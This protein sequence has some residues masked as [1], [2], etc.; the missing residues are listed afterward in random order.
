MTKVVFLYCEL[1][2]YT[3]AGLKSLLERYPE[4]D[5]TVV[6]WGEN[7]LTPFSFQALDGMNYRSL[8][9]FDSVQAL[10]SYC[11]RIN[12]D[13]VFVNSWRAFG[14]EYMSASKY[15]LQKGVPTICM[16]DNQWLGTMKQWLAVW[17]SPF[18]LK[19]HF[20]L[21]WGSGD[22]QVD[23]ALRAGYT[24]A[25]I[26][27]GFY[28]CDVELY[29]SLN[30][31][32]RRNVKN[33]LFVGRFVKVKG[34]GI[35]LRAFEEVVKDFPD[36]TLTLVGIGDIDQFMQ[37]TNP[38]VIVEQ[39][40]QPKDLVGFFEKAT[41]FCLPSVFEPWG[42]VIHEA[43]A[44]GLP[45]VCSDACGAGDAFVRD[46]V[47]GYVFRKGNQI[48]LTDALRGL[49]NKSNEELRSMGEV[50]RELASTNTPAIWAETFVNIVDVALTAH[51]K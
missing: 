37:K 13:V 7:K 39:F 2:G 24:K 42:V 15:F 38:N 22:R 14:S 33:I 49:M 50:S 20:G 27:K 1:M 40:R 30:F 36:W 25:E 46:G 41:F 19:R 43:A 51:S 44:A 6:S 9:E 29:G 8:S 3:L 45:I 21:M 26:F 32:T 11:E 28:T 31:E 35:L 5:L 18:F 16:F 48:A 23:F 34:I 10:I 17:T 12:P 47:N 4:I